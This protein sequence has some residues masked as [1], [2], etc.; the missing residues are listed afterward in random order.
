MDLGIAGRRAAVAAAS[1]GLGFATARALAAEGVRVA[2]CSRERARVEAAALEIGGG[3]IPL[4]CDVAS[5]EGARGFVRAARE[6]LGGLDILVANGGGPP[7]GAA[8][9]V[10]RAQQRESLERCFLALQAMVEEAL[11]GLQAQRWGRI[12]AITSIGVRQPLPNMVY[13][14]T[15]R[16]A[17]TAYLKTLAREVA[18][19]GVTVNSL[20]PMAIETERLRQLV[21]GNV[22]L[23][24]KQSPSARLGDAA[25]FGRIAAFLCSQAANYLTGVAMPV[26]G[27]FSVGLW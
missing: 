11:P 22:E 16:A 17:F 7:P 26:D 18:A 3:A 2:I 9:G 10:D 1:T 25:D 19:S 12:V 24:A 14:N 8:V 4:V 5:D 27:G 15:A 13:S 20:L 21:G 6:A 23:F